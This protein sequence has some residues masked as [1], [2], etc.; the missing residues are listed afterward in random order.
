[1]FSGRQGQSRLIWF[2]CGLSELTSGIL[3]CLEENAVENSDP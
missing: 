1:M 2:G 3:Y